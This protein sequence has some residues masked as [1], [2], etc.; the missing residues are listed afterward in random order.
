MRSLFI[1]IISL[2]ALTLVA[3]S[4]KSAPPEHIENKKFDPKA[5]P[6]LEE[7]EVN[8]TFAKKE[9]KEYQQAEAPSCDEKNVWQISL[10]GSR[11]DVTSLK[12]KDAPVTGRF[13]RYS[14]NIV[15]DKEESD[16]GGVGAIDLSSWNSDNLPR[17][18]RVKRFILG[19]EK[20]GE[21]VAPFSFSITPWKKTGT[22]KA[23]LS[24]DLTLNKRAHKMEIP[25]NITR[26]KKK[27]TMNST[28][29]G[30]LVY[31][32]NDSMSEIHKLLER[33]NHHFLSSFVDIG[34]ESTFTPGC[35]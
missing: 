8:T 4:G 24:I 16:A 17:D 20:E 35:K 6:I 13:D 7:P 5:I 31:A 18:N 30:R 32:S 26:T 12:N 15:T 3:F 23:S 19:V 14:M 28:G 10:P 33:C 29:T 25:V 1:A 34:F 2:Y 27:L 21:S 9:W 11:L 22:W